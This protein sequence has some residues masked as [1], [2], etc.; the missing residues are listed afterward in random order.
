MR[1]RHA[2]AYHNVKGN[3]VEQVMVAEGHVILKD[4]T[5]LN[6]HPIVMVEFVE[7][8]VVAVLA[9]NAFRVLFALKM[10]YFYLILATTY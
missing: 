1:V 10:V 7:M 9:A 3:R 2:Y 4:V 8:M 6:V 5:A